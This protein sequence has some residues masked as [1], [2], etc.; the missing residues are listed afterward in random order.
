MTIFRPCIDIHE[1]QVKQI[2]GSSL[3]DT[4]ALKTNFESRQPSSFYGELYRKN[5][6]T[7]AHIIKLGPGNEAAA[8]EALKSWPNKMQLGGG[9]TIDNA[10]YWIDAGAEKIIV[11]SWLFPSAKFSFDRLRSLSELIGKDRLVVD[12]RFV[13]LIS[14]VKQ[15]AI[16]G[17]LP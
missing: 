15:S 6:L 1:G 5:L 4:S 2:V 9:I 13:C 10:Q 8:L 7:G 12:L 16:N 3:N 14:A 17:S 11:T